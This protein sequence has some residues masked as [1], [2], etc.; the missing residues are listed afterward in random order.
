MTDGISTLLY[1]Y[2][3]YCCWLQCFCFHTRDGSVYTPSQWEM[4][5]HCNAISHWLGAYTKLALHIISLAML[6]L[7][8][9]KQHGSICEAADTGAHLVLPGHQQL[10]YW[11]CK[12]GRPWSSMRKDFNYLCHFSVEGWY[13][14][15]IYMQIY[16]LWYFC[17]PWQSVSHSFLFNWSVIQHSHISLFMDIVVHDMCYCCISLSGFID[18]NDDCF[19][20]HV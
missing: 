3:G 19:I 9:S 16:A 2:T 8:H 18:V 20:Y 5:L 14:M 10:W 11:L 17:W 15:Q 12:M 6:V 4:A 1:L 7:H 13:K